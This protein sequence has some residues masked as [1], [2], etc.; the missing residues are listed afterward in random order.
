MKYFANYWSAKKYADKNHY[1]MCEYGDYSGTGADCISYAC[2]N[3]TGDRDDEA[4]VECYYK[5][6]QEGGR[7]RPEKRA[8]AGLKNT[9]YQI[10]GVRV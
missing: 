8:S 7:W 5:W 3:K 2:W 9:I 4:Q 6:E 1:K 10:T